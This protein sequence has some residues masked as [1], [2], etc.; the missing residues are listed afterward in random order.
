MR[1]LPGAIDALPAEIVPFC[2]LLVPL[3]GAFALK[4]AALGALSQS[5]TNQYVTFTTSEACNVTGLARIRVFA[6]AL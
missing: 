1:V 6:S 5:H 3:R 4:R 2:A